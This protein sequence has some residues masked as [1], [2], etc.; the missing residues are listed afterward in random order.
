MRGSSTMLLL[1]MDQMPFAK[2]NYCFY[3]YYYN[4]LLLS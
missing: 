3:Y 4:E 2:V 1:R